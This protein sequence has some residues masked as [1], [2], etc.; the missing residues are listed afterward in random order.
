MLRNS[1]RKFSYDAI[2]VGGGHNGLT[3][4]AYL[5]KAGKKVCVLERRHVIGGAAVTEEIIPGYRFSRASYLLSL[6][7]PL[8]IQEL[9]LKKFGLRYHIRNPSSFTPIRSSSDSLL[10][11]LNM[12]ENQ[13]EIAKFS[14]RDA[15]NFPKYEHFISTIVKAFE[16]LM[17]NEP[18]DFERSLNKRLAQ[19]YLLYN[20]VK[21]LGIAN[22]ADFYEL[23][24][25]PISKV[26]NKW[27]DSDVLKATLGTDGVIGLAASPYDA[28]TG[29]PSPR[30]LLRKNKS[31]QTHQPGPRYCKPYAPRTF[32]SISKD[33]FS[34]F[35]TSNV[36]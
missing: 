5:A 14:K 16:P 29:S 27:F 17:D 15:E 24:T 23:M 32:L 3:A 19:L 22:I 34:G 1:V 21:P 6:L 20:T 8:V 9:D 18:L 4:A 31:N 13:K 12:S 7:R 26:M 36:Y 11:G 33:S 10:L 35:S 28:G 25:A 30:R 2:I